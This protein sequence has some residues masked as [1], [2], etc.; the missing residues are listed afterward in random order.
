MIWRCLYQAEFREQYEVLDRGP[1]SE[2]SDDE[3]GA[4]MD[5]A[6]AHDAFAGSGSDEDGDGMIDVDFA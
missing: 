2:S 6:F 4:G 1:L 5:D 3:L